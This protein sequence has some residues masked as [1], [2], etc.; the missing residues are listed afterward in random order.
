[1]WNVLLPLVWYCVAVRLTG[2]KV[3]VE[4]ELVVGRLGRWVQL[5]VPFEEA[6]MVEGGVAVSHHALQP[7]SPVR[8][9]TLDGGAVKE[10]THQV[11]PP[12]HVVRPALHSVV[13]SERVRLDLDE[14]HLQGVEGH[15]VVVERHVRIQ[16]LITFR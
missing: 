15:A 13:G 8:Y 2:K 7:L 9:Y 16:Q 1:M 14:Y 11:V 6:R 5:W 10:T 4:E 3:F 12:E